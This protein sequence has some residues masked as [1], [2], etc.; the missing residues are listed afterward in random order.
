MATKPAK[1][2][3]RPKRTKAETDQEFVLIQEELAEA[4]GSSREFGA[5]GGGSSKGPGS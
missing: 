5:Q 3:P 4:R 2:P 1:V